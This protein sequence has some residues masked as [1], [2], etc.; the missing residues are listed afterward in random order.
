MNKAAATNYLRH[1]WSLA[2]L[3]VGYIA[4][5]APS[6]QEFA[7][8]FL[9][10]AAALLPAYLWASGRVHGIPI[11]PLFGLTYVM[12]YAIPLVID[13]YAIA[14]FTL[15]EK[16]TA[17]LT[18][19]GFLLLTTL[20]WFVHCRATRVHRL[21]S[22][23]RMIRG[24]HPDRLLLSL[25]VLA[26]FFILIAF[27]GWFPFDAIFFTLIKQFSLAMGAVSVFALGVR[28]GQG[29]MTRS[30]R[31]IFLVLL[32]ANIIIASS[33]LFLVGSATTAVLAVT[34]Y[35]KGSG[36]VPWV[37]MILLVAVF[38]LLH[39]GKGEMRAQYWDEQDRRTVQF[40]EYPRFFAKWFNASWYTLFEYDTMENSSSALARLS[41]I[42]MLMKVQ[43]ETP[44]P[45]P[46]LAGESYKV[47]PELLIPRIFYPEKLSAQEGMTL[48]NLHYNTQ[49]RD[50]A[51]LTA[52]GW[53]MLAE[54]YANFGYRGCV[55]LAI[56]FG[57]FYGFVTRWSQDY[58]VTSARFLFA[59]T[60][61]VV[62]IQSE[63]AASIYFTSLFQA[64]MSVLAISLVVMRNADG[65]ER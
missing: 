27:S 65:A 47:I 20:V 36:R 10:V 43:A 3:L 40:W 53:G 19:A 26:T 4:W 42:N 8:A 21:P 58:P 11:V 34:G 18:T 15:Q 1:F 16:W 6:M 9:V 48:M 31:W 51:D 17:A 60:V 63:F 28:F 56:F 39:L 14:V 61:L 41:V 24:I 30:A 13:H 64:A 7:M 59:I 52:I 46:Y 49:T 12:A 2:M 35:V 29:S 54:S 23:I 25:F 44:E 33:G 38:S 62:A 57:L 22:R 55:I 50:D 32:A 5:M 45:T 37:M